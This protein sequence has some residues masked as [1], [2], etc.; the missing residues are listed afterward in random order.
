MAGRYNTEEFVAIATLVAG[1]GVRGMS[2]GGTSSGRRIR[3]ACSF[4][5]TQTEFCAQ[6]RKS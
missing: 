5:T 3:L 4:A 6:K 1:A 2:W